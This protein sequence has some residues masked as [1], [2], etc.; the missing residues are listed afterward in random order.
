MVPRK[1]ILCIFL[2]S[3]LYKIDEF[4]CYNRCK[5]IIL[6]FDCEYLVQNWREFMVRNAMVFNHNY[7]AV[8]FNNLLSVDNV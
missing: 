2:C 1:I 8:K 6:M 7:G 3:A 4:R 5:L